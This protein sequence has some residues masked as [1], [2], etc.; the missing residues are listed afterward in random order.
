MKKFVFTNEKYYKIKLDEDDR[1]KL[2]LESVDK[3]I[4]LAVNELK[5]LDIRAENEGLAYREDMRTGTTAKKLA[6][7]EWFVPYLK[8]LREAAQKKLEELQAQRL[9]LQNL[10]VKTRNDIRV[11][12]QMKQEQYEQYLKEVAAEEAKELDSHISFNLFNKGAE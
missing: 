1:L 3:S 10:L 8:E 11:L 5:E 9:R 4:E 12:E 2:E 7:Y 6:T